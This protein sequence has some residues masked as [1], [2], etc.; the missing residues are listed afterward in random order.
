[1]VGILS[2]I[3][4]KR[5]SKP[6][7]LSSHPVQRDHAIIIEGS[8]GGMVTAAYLTKY[9]SRITIIESDD[10]LGDA[11]M[12]STPNELLDYRCQLSSPTS[13]GR[14]GVP[15]MYQLHVLEGEGYKI[16]QELFPRLTDILFNEYNIRTYVLGK[17]SR[18]II[19]GTLLNQNL[20]QE[21]RWL[22]VDR[23]TLDT[24]LRRE[25]CAQCGSQIEWKCKSR[26]TKLLVDR[27]LNTVQGVQ[28]HCKEDTSSSSVDLYGDFII[29]CSGKN[30]SSTKWLK[31]SLDLIV[32]S[33][34]LHFGVGYVT[35]IGERF[36]TG[37]PS[38]DQM[39]IIAC[40]T[41][42]PKKNVAC[43]VT[44]IRMLETTDENSLGTLATIVINCVNSEFPP[45][46]S[47][48]HLLEWAKE[49]L[50]PDFYA[51]LK[52]TKVHSPLLPYRRAI[53][54]RKYVELLGKKWPRNYVMLGDALYVH[55][56]LNWGKA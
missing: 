25:L 20:I 43:S 50:D 48:E 13:L 14:S 5:N 18:I 34:Q 32:P 46:D 1:M 22:G 16:L 15:Q 33:V 2:Y 52:S 3:V 12:K 37:N 38:L 51:I 55:S 6:S 19:D 41:I 31:E 47:F 28:Y 23:F 29:D 39:P 44:P 35:F 54:D 24:V 10:V 56:I 40:T 21:M 49:N 45:N 9:F 7:E 17:E 8:I 30:S 53:D 11:L 4:Y 42:A 26:V 36:K 27:S